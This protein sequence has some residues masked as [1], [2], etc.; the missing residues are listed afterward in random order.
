[1]ANTATPKPMMSTMT[2]YTMALT[3][4]LCMACDRSKCAMRRWRTSVIAPLASPALIMLM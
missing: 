4:L 2:G 1:M 3:T